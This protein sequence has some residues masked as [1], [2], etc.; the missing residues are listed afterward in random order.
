MREVA[1]KLK[2]DL[3]QYQEVVRFARFGTEVDEATQRQIQRGVRLEA[4]LKQ[5]EHEP[6]ELADMIAVM[7]AASGGYLDDVLPAEVPAFERYILSRLHAEQ[8]NEIQEIN[9]TGELS[10]EVRSR[11]VSALTEF[12][13]AW[14]QRS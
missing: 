5:P 2:L 12:R 4:A 11:L 6:L 9:Q 8:E 10:D 1:G 7:M 14:A 13:A 3:A